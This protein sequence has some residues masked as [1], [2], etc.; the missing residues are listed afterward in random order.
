MGT[1]GHGT[2]ARLY[3]DV[4]THPKTLRLAD[5]LEKLG[6]P[7]RYAVREAVGQLHE[8]L[9]WCLGNA[10]DG[11][12]GHLRP[13]MFARVVG[14]TDAGKADALLTAW[15][16]SGFLE[17]AAQGSLSGC[18]L[19]DFE[20]CAGDIIAKRR[21]RREA[22]TAAARP[23]HGRRADADRTPHGRRPDA[24]ARAFGSG[25]GNGTPPNPPTTSPPHP[26]EPPDE[27]P[28][29]SVSATPRTGPGSRGGSSRRRAHDAGERGTAATATPPAAPPPA[30]VPDDAPDDAGDHGPAQPDGGLLAVWNA[31]RA[32]HGLPAESLTPAMLEAF[33]GLR[34]AAGGDV[35][36]A[37]LVVGEFFRQDDPT[38]TSAG[39]SLRLFPFRRD[40][41]LAEAKRRMRRAAPTPPPPPAGPVASAAARSA[42]LAARAAAN[43]GGFVAAKLLGT[44]PAEPDEQARRAAGLQFLASQSAPNARAR[45]AVAGGA[46]GS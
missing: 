41:C 45:E 5:A 13:A 18:R 44:V 32:R 42:V 3:G 20:E 33:D 37:A 28:G 10:D 34:E 19:H 1:K 22:K 39:W 27:A 38:V 26:P 17:D 6:V 14:W 7:P 8:L 25:N 9:V 30:D 4:W 12:I 31:G 36:L 46:H 2:Y 43:P 16:A 15:K 23:P 35:A 24:L 21:A 29:V 11:E 40:G